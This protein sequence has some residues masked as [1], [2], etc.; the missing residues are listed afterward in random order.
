YMMEATLGGTMRGVMTTVAAVGF[1]PGMLFAP[2]IQKKL[3]KKKMTLLSFAGSTLI[4]ALMLLLVLFAFESPV[5][6]WV[7]F[8]GVFLHNIFAALWT[9]TMPAMTADYCEYQQWKTGER[10]DG[11]MS[12]YTTVITTICGMFTS[13]LTSELL[14][15]LG[16]NSSTDYANHDVLRKVFIF[17]G[18]AGIVCGVL[19]IIPFLFWDLS[20][21]KQLAMARDIKIRSLN[22]K[23]EDNSLEQDDIKE[24]ITLGVLTADRAIAMGFEVEVEPQSADETLTATEAAI[25]NEFAGEEVTTDDAQK[26]DDYKF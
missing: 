14:I 5:T 11:Y 26:T 16:A 3:G 7:Y 12:Q 18:V 6:P 8:V 1:V 25:A 19:A 24:A 22:E 2:L 13:L 4:S 17:W 15:K 10:L 9:V 21:A 23:L 20:E